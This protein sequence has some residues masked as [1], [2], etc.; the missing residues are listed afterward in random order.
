M[1]IGLGSNQY[2]PDVTVNQQSYGYLNK[3]VAGASDITLTDFEATYAQIE[4]T[5]VLTGNINVF[6]SNAENMIW[7]YNNTTGTFTITIRPTGGSGITLTQG[8]RAL[9][10]Y[11]GAGNAYKW[12]AEL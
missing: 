5:G 3:N 4:L 10:G 8:T 1:T 7:F 9:I 12:T 11:D 2:Q 6:Q